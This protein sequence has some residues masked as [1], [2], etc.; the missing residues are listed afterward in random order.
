MILNVVFDIGGVLINNDPKVQ[1]ESLPYPKSVIAAM[2]KVI[3]CSSIWE[4][5]D[6]GIYSTQDE[7]LPEFIDQDP[8]IERELRTFFKPG[9]MK[10]IYLLNHDAQPLF[11]LCCGHLHVFLLSNYAKDG[12]EFLRDHFAFMAKPEGIMISAFEGLRK[13]DPRIYQRLLQKFR[14]KASE[15]VLI[16][17]NEEN[18]QKAEQC[19]LNGIHYENATQTEKMLRKLLLDSG[20]HILP[21]L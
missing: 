10:D 11:N 3:Y 19:G 6:L 18:I 12:Y 15:T 7:A 2:T 1:I 14:L 4:K 20:N 17:D 16:D 13:P 9:W 8:R 5:L 21:S